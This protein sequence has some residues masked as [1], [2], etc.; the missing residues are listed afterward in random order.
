M[1]VWKGSKAG[2]DLKQP[3]E[4]HWLFMFHYN[5]MY[6]MYSH[7]QKKRLNTWRKPVWKSETLSVELNGP[8]CSQQFLL[9]FL[10]TLILLVCNVLLCFGCRFRGEAFQPQRVPAGPH[11]PDDA[12]LGCTISDVRPETSCTISSTVTLCSALVPLVHCSQSHV[13]VH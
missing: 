1:W 6:I 13:H 11:D 10:A 3:S 9:L 4:R 5:I 12:Q 8:P 7:R 2:I